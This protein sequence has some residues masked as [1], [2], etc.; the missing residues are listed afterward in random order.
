M[1]EDELADIR[2]RERNRVLAAVC[3]ELELDMDEAAS[4]YMNIVHGGDT[5]QSDDWNDAY[6]FTFG[7]NQ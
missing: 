5:N 1:T 7:E 2:A 3:R 4:L 6:S